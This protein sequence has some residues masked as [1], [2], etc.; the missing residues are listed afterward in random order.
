MDWNDLLLLVVIPVVQQVIKWIS[1]KTGYTFEKWLNQAIS[2]VLAGVFAFLAG[3]FAG[4]EVPVWSG[5]VISFVGGIL[6]LIG[7]AWGAVMLVYE[8]IWDRL[9]TKIG[10][11]TRDKYS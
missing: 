2:L 6:A 7:A 5:D 11:A 8:V 4:L 3:D 1:D 9:F 10:F